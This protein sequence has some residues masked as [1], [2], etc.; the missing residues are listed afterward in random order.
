MEREYLEL[1]YAENDK[2]F[3][4]ITE[5]FRISKYMG[6]ANVTL[7]RLSSKEWEKTLTKTDEEL[8]K[9]A[10]SILETNAR[11]QMVQ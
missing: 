8:Q 4:P 6:D 2:L 1:H 9:I 7:T 3:V 10:E 11:R 5:I